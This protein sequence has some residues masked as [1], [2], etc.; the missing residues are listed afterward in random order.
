MQFKDPA[1]VYNAY[2]SDPINPNNS[3]ANTRGVFQVEVTD[4]TLSLQGSVGGPFM[5]IQAFSESGIYEVVLANAMRV[6][7]TG[8]AKAWVVR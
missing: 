3:G 7:A 6:V 8:N 4:G 5:E 2:T 1:G